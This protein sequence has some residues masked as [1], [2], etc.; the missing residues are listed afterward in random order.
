MNGAA[1]GTSRRGFLGRAAGAAAVVAGAG[2]GAGALTQSAAAADQRSYTAGRFA[3]DIDGVST[4][5]L[6]G[7]DGGHSEGNVI[8]ED[9][10]PGDNIQKKHIAG[11]KY[12][13]FTV[14]VGAGMGAGMYS[15]IQD[16]FDKGPTPRHISIASYDSS[17]KE[18][19]RRA[20]SAAITSLT[21]PALDRSTKYEAY[22]ALGLEV[23]GTV[24]NR[25]PQGTQFQATGKRKPFLTQNGVF[26]IDGIDTSR[27]ATVD[28]FTWTCSVAA[29]GSVL[30]EVSDLG[31]TFPRADASSWQEWYRNMISG[32][33][34][35]ERKGALTLVGAD[36][37]EV[38][39]FSFSNVGLY[40][41]YSVTG[42]VQPVGRVK[43]AMVR[44]EAYVERVSCQ[45]SHL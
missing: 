29:D 2:V 16:S 3:L 26:E 31:I 24:T 1:S 10:Q 15:W 23:Q 11:V 32:G 42:E 18:K 19:S 41:L 38:V 8:V 12:E 21:V 22:C 17:G 39:T 7:V 14:Q 45:C 40:K 33:G 20:A 28:S 34:G 27:V 37:G 43:Q 9:Q 25:P 6:A 35:D 4:G 13:D 36:G 44:A 30:M 5:R